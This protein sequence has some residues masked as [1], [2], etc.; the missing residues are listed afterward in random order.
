[1]R[2]K[3][4]EKTIFAESLVIIWLMYAVSKRRLL[5]SEK[6]L[7]SYNRKVR[8]KCREF[9]QFLQNSVYLVS[10]SENEIEIFRKEIADLTDLKCDRLNLLKLSRDDSLLIEKQFIESLVI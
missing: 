4:L 8:L 9:G 7:E 3:L 2:F 10:L 1:M 5:T 6:T